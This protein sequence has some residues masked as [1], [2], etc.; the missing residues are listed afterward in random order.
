MT[1]FSDRASRFSTSTISYLAKFAYHHDAI[2]PDID[3]GHTKSIAVAAIYGYVVAARDPSYPI[4]ATH[5]SHR[6]LG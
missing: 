6:S 2:G 3:H 5:T 4:T 1:H